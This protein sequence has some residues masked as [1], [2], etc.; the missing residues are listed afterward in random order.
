M[1]IWIMAGALALGGCSSLNSLRTDLSAPAPSTD[2]EAEALVANLRE[3]YRARCGPG[4]APA[5]CQGF[6]TDLNVAGVTRFTGAGMALSDLYCD[7]FFRSTNQAARKRR[8]GSGLATD[9]STLVAGVL[10]LAKAGADG[11]TAST[12]GFNAINGTFRNYDQ[13]FMVDADLS[14]LRRLVL[15]AQ[16]NMRLRID[17]EPPKTIFAAES[18]ILRY[19]GLC[20]FLGMQ[21]L[22]NTSVTEKTAQ[23]E[24]QNAAQSKP[25]VAAPVPVAPAPGAPAAAAPPAVPPPAAVAPQ[26]LAPLPP[27]N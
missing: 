27:P 19:A 8:F 9:A 25:L 6:Q 26:V 7:R 12:L 1:R 23:I 10:N 16:D 13:S 20:S 5:D 14:K 15:S 2:R 24:Q 4:D 17:N 11:I 18:T 22:L 21:D 3:A